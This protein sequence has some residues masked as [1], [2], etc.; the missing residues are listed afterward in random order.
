MYVAN[1]YHRI[2]E[3]FSSIPKERVEKDRIVEE[4]V[5]Q[6]APSSMVLLTWFR[7]ERLMD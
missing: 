7:D 3:C 5:P 2:A 1:D 6:D 4:T